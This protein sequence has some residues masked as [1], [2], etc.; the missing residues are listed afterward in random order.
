MKPHKLAKIRK[1]QEPKLKRYFTTL[2]NKG[3]VRPTNQGH[4]F[5]PNCHKQSMQVESRREFG[6]CAGLEGSRPSWMKCAMSCGYTCS[7]DDVRAFYAT[8]AIKYTIGAQL[9]HT[10]GVPPQRKDL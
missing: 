10:I 4:Y 2:G 3:D 9:E 5:C 8:M 6:T 7:Y 1:K